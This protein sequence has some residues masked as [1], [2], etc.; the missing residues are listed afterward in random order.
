MKHFWYINTGNIFSE[1]LHDVDKVPMFYKSILTAGQETL[2]K[3]LTPLFL[4]GTLDKA[5]HLS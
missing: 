2:Q 3:G 4:P 5:S 1:C